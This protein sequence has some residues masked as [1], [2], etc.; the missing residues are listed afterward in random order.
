MPRVRAAAI[1]SPPSVPKFDVVS[2]GARVARYTTKAMMDTPTASQGPR[3]KPPER[4]EDQELNRSLMLIAISAPYAGVYPQWRNY[5]MVVRFHQFCES[6]SMEP[7]RFQCQ[8]P[9]LHSGP[10]SSIMRAGRAAV[11]CCVGGDDSTGS[12]WYGASV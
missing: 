8:P 12:S 11:V 2:P 4:P 3:Q 5:T 9:F 1:K 10:K 7:A 6:V